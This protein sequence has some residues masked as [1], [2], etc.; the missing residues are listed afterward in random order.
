MDYS[1]AWLYQL[2]KQIGKKKQDVNQSFF[3]DNREI[4]EAIHISLD[5]LA[6]RCSLSL[7]GIF[8]K[9]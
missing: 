4:E 7:G 5:V 6:V 8:E 2:E 3:K 9:N 1:Q